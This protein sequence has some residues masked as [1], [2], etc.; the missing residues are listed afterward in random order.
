MYR[1]G[2]IDDEMRQERHDQAWAVQAKEKDYKS[3]R[4]YSMERSVR[5]S[6]KDRYSVAER[7]ETLILRKSWTRFKHASTNKINGIWIFYPWRN[8]LQMAIL[9]ENYVFTVFVSLLQRIQIKDVES[10]T[11]WIS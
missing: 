10:G 5:H 7:I 6:M 1:K 8:I 2:N 11:S 3:Q 9:L 4:E